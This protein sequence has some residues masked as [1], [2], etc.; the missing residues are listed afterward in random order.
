MSYRFSKGRPGENEIIEPD[1]LNQNFKEFVD[2]INGSLTRE[3]LQLDDDETLKISQFK[4]KTFCE[5]FQSSKY[6]TKPWESGG[7]AFEPSKNTTGYISVDKHGEE[8][9]NIEFLAERDGWIIYDFNAS[10]LWQGTGLLSADEAL[11]MLLVKRH[12]P[13]AHYARLAMH[14]SELPVGGWVGITCKNDEEMGI[15]QDGNIDIYGLEDI[16]D[17]DEHVLGD[18]VYDLD[19]GTKS[20]GLRHRDFPQG[21]YLIQST[22][23]YGIRYRVTL[24]GSEISETGWLFNGKDRNGVYLCG[25]IPV[26][27]GRNV[28]KTEVSAANVENIWGVSQGI[29]SEVANGDGEPDGKKGRYFPKSFVSSEN[30]LSTLPR[31]RT[32]TISKGDADLQHGMKKLKQ[33]PYEINLGI[34]CR[35]GAANLVLQYRKG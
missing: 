29:R 22:D 18:A 8:M 19:F 24:N 30:S 15:P 23:R 4:N 17:G 12:W 26:R 28:I 25:V 6:A 11:R 13:V 5:V 35:V 27:A 14:K 20:T 21:K 31:R 10:H 7:A 32:I 3:N 2:E 16:I 33:N 1:D 9:P 34:S